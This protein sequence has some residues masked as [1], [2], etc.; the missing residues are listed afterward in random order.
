MK[1]VLTPLPNESPKAFSAFKAYAD[2]GDRRS[3]RAVARKLH[4]SVTLLAR[5]SK[6]FRWQERIA[7]LNVEDVMRDI[8]ADKRAKL[9]VA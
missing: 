3:I 7:A 6:K 2:L 9:A 5:W 1:T 8:A 4:K